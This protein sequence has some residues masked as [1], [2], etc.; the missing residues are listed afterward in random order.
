MRAGLHRHEEGRAACTFARLLECD[1]LGCG[2]PLPFVPAFADDLAV[3]NDDGADD[4]IR[5]RRPAPALRELERTLEA[6]ASS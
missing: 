1:H 2:S 4:R 3:P 6:H 5:V